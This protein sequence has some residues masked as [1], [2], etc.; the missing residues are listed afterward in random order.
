ME[1]LLSDIDDTMT[2]AGKLTPDAYKAL[3]RLSESGI[4]VIPVT[5]RPAGWCDMIVRQWPVDAVI[6]E[7]G[8]FTLYMKDSHLH[9]M[10]HPSIEEGQIREKLGDIRKAV[11]HQ[12]PGSRVAKD[13][14]YR[15]YDLAIDFREDPPE[16]GLSA[17]EEIKAICESF[18]A[19]AKIS[20]IHVNAWF[21]E[22]DKLSMAKHM[23]K[24]LWKVD[25]A[26][27]RILF[28]GDSVN[29]EP[30]FSAFPVSVGV[31]NIRNFLHLLKAF[32]SFVTEAPFGRGFTEAVNIL[33][34][35]RN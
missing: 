30:M 6:G 22:Y 27:D 15:L 9:R 2:E 26:K 29:D 34:S 4:R 28:C 23:L 19:Q 18:G 31:S 14:P 20:S 10:D 7:N 1:F 17:A 5:G 12:V 21:G 32:P 8:A 33:L 25:D 16:L 13:Q 3:W 24:A 35:R 11:L